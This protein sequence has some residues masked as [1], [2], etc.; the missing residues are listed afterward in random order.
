MFSLSFKRLAFLSL[1]CFI[2][3]GM[4]TGGSVKQMQQ[5]QSL[6]GRIWWQAVIIRV[7]VAIIVTI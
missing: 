1:R 7:I 5:A 2:V 6:A 3:G 4:Q